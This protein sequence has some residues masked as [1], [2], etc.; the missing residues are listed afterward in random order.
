M[1]KKLFKAKKNWVIGIIAGALLMFG[2]AS[3]TGYADTGSN[4]QVNTEQ[5]SNHNNVSQVKPTQQKLVLQSVPTYSHSHET[6]EIHVVT[7]QDGEQADKYVKSNAY[8]SPNGGFGLQKESIRKSDVNNF[9]DVKSTGNSHISYI[10]NGYTYSIHNNENNQNAQAIN[11]LSQ[12]ISYGDSKQIKKYLKI[13]KEDKRMHFKD[14]GKTVFS[15]KYKLSQKDRDKMQKLAWEYRPKIT[16]DRVYKGHRIT[17]LLQTT[18][19]NVIRIVMLSEGWNGFTFKDG[20]Q[21]K[22]TDVINDPI[23]VAD[24]LLGKF[25]NDKYETGIKVN[26]AGMPILSNY[27]KLEKY[28]IGDTGVVFLS[29]GIYALFNGV[30]Q[31]YAP[32]MIELP[33]TLLKSEYADFYGTDDA[34]DIDKLDQD[35]LKDN[36]GGVKGASDVI[37]V[38]TSKDIAKHHKPSVIGKVIADFGHFA[39]SLLEDISK[40]AGAIVEDAT[41]LGG[42][43]VDLILQSK[44]EL[45]EA[46]DEFFAWFAESTRLGKF[47]HNLGAAS[48]IV[49]ATLMGVKYD[50][51]SK[52]SHK[53]EKDTTK[54]TSIRK[55]DFKKERSN[56]LGIIN[57]A[58]NVLMDAISAIPGVGFAMALLGLLVP[59]AALYIFKMHDEEGYLAKFNLRKKK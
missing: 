42:K 53:D 24:Y 28:V 9:K 48:L 17:S 39:N 51:M 45:L 36:Y 38:T 37:G 16:F 23:K 58:F 8:V 14:N 55:G 15:F 7:K 10:S 34:V 50:K 12:A 59:A 22:F 40:G 49:D 25:A 54:S 21:I 6:D 5:V 52:D 30:S 31:G 19:T 13:S 2:G 44:K 29:D 26:E 1:R 20:K 35:Y 18:Y 47:M 56:R 41:K 27:D 4:N 32:I 11:N 43:L 33:R 3:V 46:K 57:S